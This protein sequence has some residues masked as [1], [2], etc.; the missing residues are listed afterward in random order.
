MFKYLAFCESSYRAHFLICSNCVTVCFNLASWGWC[1]VHSQWFMG[2]V[3][4]L[5]LNDNV[6]SYTLMTDRGKHKSMR[7]SLV[8]LRWPWVVYRN[9]IRMG[10]QAEIITAS[11]VRRLTKRKVDVEK[12]TASCRLI[13]KCHSNS[14]QIVCFITSVMLLFV[15]FQ[16]F[17]IS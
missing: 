12:G 16:C 14:T 15:M 4:S 5:P 8:F 17:Q 10:K 3:K 7:R 2:E 13:F 11:Q 6:I 1:S 9:Q